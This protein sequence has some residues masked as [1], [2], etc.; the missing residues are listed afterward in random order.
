[1]PD[2]VVNTLG[3]LPPVP[4]GPLASAIKR[5]THEALA[6]LP[7]GANGARVEISHDKGIEL[8][9][10]HRSENGRWTVDAWVGK[11][12][13]KADSPLEYGATATILW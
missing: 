11:N 9:F 6:G 3:P 10:A 1:M 2:G 8:A 7:P 4:E 12:F 13:Y 5:V